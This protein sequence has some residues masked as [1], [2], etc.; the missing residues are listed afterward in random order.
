MTGP[1]VGPGFAAE[2]FTA[3]RRRMFKHSGDVILTPIAFRGLRARL[4]A[5]CSLVSLAVQSLRSM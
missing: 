2:A 5:S 4:I 3:T 1:A